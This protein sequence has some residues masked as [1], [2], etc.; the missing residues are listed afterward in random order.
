MY[1]SA[2][3]E[4]PQLSAS[5]FHSSQSTFYSTHQSRTA[6]GS[7]V[8]VI[9]PLSARSLN[10][11]LRQSQAVQLS[12][13][14]ADS[15]LQGIHNRYEKEVQDVQQN[16][17]KHYSD[18]R[19][20]GSTVVELE[21][22][23]ETEQG[24][25]EQLQARY[26]DHM[27]AYE[28]EKRQRLHLARENTDLRTEMK[29]KDDLIMDYEKRLEVTQQSRS[30]M[31]HENED[32]CNEVK[33]MSE[34]YNVKLKEIESKYVAESKKFEEQN[35]ELRKKIRELNEENER[36]IRE[37]I[38]EYDS[39][40]RS[41]ENH[42]REKDR[43]ISECNAEIQSIKQ[44]NMKVKMEYEEEL[45][46]QLAHVKYEETNKHE[47]VVKELEI[48]IK[49]LESEKEQVK[50]KVEDTAQDV[51]DKEKVLKDA[52]NWFTE[53]I[54]SLKKQNMD[55]KD[56]ISWDETEIE[57]LQGEIR[58]KDS[59]VIKLQTEIKRLDG[60]IRHQK[61]SLTKE[62][63]KVYNRNDADVRRFQ[64]YEQQLVKRIED[65]DALLRASETENG[66]LKLDLERF[67]EKVSTNIQRSIIQ[68]FGEY[69]VQEG[70]GEAQAQDQYYS[71]GQRQ[72]HYQNQNQNQSQYQSQ[73]RQSHYQNQNQSQYQSQQRQSHYQNQNQSQ[74][75]S[76]QRQSQRRDYY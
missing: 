38:R 16:Y 26:N 62:N 66:Q 67:R 73:Q 53:Q 71:Q 3:K 47:P 75:Q 14:Q 52:K 24:R 46:R 50:Q 43:I 33:R 19:N 12:Y 68:T 35:E 58:G 7:A 6:P 45:R 70:Q 64:E 60:E 21:G 42:I 51:Q 32:L 9:E 63:T 10:N 54:Q 27:R 13:Y 20:L 11:N 48:R 57:R 29:R 49:Q 76:Q 41:F 25:L 30:G 65:L 4:R 74:Y 5:T 44:F 40:Y 36:K 56:R 69:G 55:L 23:L 37:T 8:K 2:K 17:E 28:Q 22:L 34:L 31:T 15:K 61:E 39:K 59:S 72:S 18:H 1:Y